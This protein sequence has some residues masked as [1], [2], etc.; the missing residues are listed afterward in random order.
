MIP[1]AHQ[2]RHRKSD[3]GQMMESSQATLKRSPQ[4]NIILNRFTVQ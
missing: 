2:S 1:L 4:Y 3:F